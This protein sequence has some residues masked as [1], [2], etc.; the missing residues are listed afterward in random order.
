MQTNFQQQ[1]DQV[2]QAAGSQE[3]ENDFI[4]I[5]ENAKDQIFPSSVVDSN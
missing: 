2:N 3:N 1:I 5:Q 4:N